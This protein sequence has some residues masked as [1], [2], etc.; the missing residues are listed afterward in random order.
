M[1]VTVVAGSPVQLRWICSG[2]GAPAVGPM[3]REMI[4]VMMRTE[5]RNDAARFTV[6]RL[7]KLDR[8][9]KEFGTEIPWRVM[10]CKKKTFE[11]LLRIL[12]PK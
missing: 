1:T 12:L 11:E 8:R 9:F 7:L 6:L 2:V 10:R 4:V 3:S 5:N